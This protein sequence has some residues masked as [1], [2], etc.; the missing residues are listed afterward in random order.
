MS[1]KN[2][3]WK[4]FG[5]AV[6]PIAF[7][8]FAIL[9]P[10]IPGQKLDNSILFLILLAILI[11][12]LPWE[13]LTSLKAA[14]IEF[15][16][17]KPLIDKAISDLGILKGKENINDE[18][19][20]RLFER[21]IPQ[22]EESKGGRILWIDDAPR[23]VFGERRLL[24]ALNIETVMADSSELAQKYLDTD[25][26]FDL[27]VSDMREG[28]VT[29]KQK[30]G[31]PEA[32][33]FIVKLREMEAKRSQMSRY[34]NIPSLPVVIYSGQSYNQLRRLTEPI[35]RDGSIIIIST[36]T[37]NFFEE[38]IRVLSDVRSEPIQIIVGS[39]VD[40]PTKRK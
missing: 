8:I 10:N 7:A 23:N 22:I 19:I 14:G 5:L 3:F 18:K 32:V 36:S 38:V 12:I 34:S 21:L 29:K 15:E 25:G 4:K 20:R 35:R 33:R 6:I 9:Y 26:D 39:T 17:D 24:R 27:I 11:I 40:L 2:I 28:E 30:D 37:E 16:L 31:M 1:N 13:R